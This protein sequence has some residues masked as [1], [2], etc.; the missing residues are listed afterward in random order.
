LAARLWHYIT[1]IGLLLIWTCFRISIL[2][3]YNQQNAAHVLKSLIYR[4]DIN[5]ADWL[6]LIR[7]P[8]LKWATVK[9]RIEK[10]VI[11]FVK[12]DYQ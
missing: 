3:K 11:Q 8:E 2:I 5:L 4:D 7:D 1:A 12:N 9:K 6:I 10:E